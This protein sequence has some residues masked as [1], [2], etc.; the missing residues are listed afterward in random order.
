MLLVGPVNKMAAKTGDVFRRYRSA[1]FLVQPLLST[2]PRPPGPVI[3][4][5]AI[6]PRRG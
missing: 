6:L 5:S 4:V 2:G 3:C 1:I